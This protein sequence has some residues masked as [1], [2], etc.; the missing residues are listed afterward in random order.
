[1]KSGGAT[2]TARFAVARLA[3]MLAT[4]GLGLVAAYRG[5]LWFTGQGQADFFFVAGALSLA[6][7]ATSVFSWVRVSRSKPNPNTER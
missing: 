4:A 3:F 5:Y 1:M 6:F 7:A 2:V